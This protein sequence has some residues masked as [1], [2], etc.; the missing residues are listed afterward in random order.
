MRVKQDTKD[1]GELRSCAKYKLKVISLNHHQNA[2]QRMLPV[3]QVDIQ[4]IN[5]HK[6]VSDS[7]EM[8][9]GRNQGIGPLNIEDLLS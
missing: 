2:K 7:S 5:P 4:P 9:D 6:S 1:E 8:S 3:I